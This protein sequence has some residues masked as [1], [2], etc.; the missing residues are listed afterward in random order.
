MTGFTGSV[1]CARSGMVLD[2]WFREL[3]DRD[4]KQMQMGG[5]EATLQTTTADN[6]LNPR[7]SVG[8]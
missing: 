5:G 4:V 8:C 7:S 6:H 3:S 2:G 1:E